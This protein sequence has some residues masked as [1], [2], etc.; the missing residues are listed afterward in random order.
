MKIGPRIRL[1]DMDRTV[2][3]NVKTSCFS[4]L[5]TYLLVA[6]CSCVGFNDEFLECN[7]YLVVVLHHTV[8]NLFV[9]VIGVFC[10][11]LSWVFFERSILLEI[12]AEMFVVI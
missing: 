5:G 12:T 2:T 4:V 7:V 8:K 11:L 1:W 10:L 6:E 9:L 3:E